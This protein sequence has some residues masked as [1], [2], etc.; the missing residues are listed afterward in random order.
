MVSEEDTETNHIVN[1]DHKI[2]NTETLAGG[3]PICVSGVENSGHYARIL[4]R[5]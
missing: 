4:D 2:C 1:N 3:S 5:P